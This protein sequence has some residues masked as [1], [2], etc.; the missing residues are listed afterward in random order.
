MVFIKKNTAIASF[1]ILF[2][3][4]VKISFGQTSKIDSLKNQLQKF[5]I[6]DSARVN[7]LN[8]L[9]HLIHRKDIAKA[10]EYIEESTTI[11]KEIRFIKGEA[12]SIY[13]R[14]IIEGATTNYQNGLQYYEQ[15]IQLHK[16][17]NNKK[18]IAECYKGIG[19][20][21]FYKNDRNKAIEYYQKSVEIC[22]EINDKKN[23]ATSL[24]Y[25]AASHLQ[26][27]DYANVIKYAKESLAINEALNDDAGISSSSN[28]IASAYT[29]QSNYPVALEYFNKALTINEKLK[30]TISISNLLI[31]IGVIHYHQEK[32]EK[33]IGYYKKA[34]QFNTSADVLNNLGVVHKDFK[35][36][37]DAIYYLQKALKIYQETNNKSY[38]AMSYNNIADVLIEQHNYDKALTYF[39]KAQLLNTETKNKLGISTSLLGIAK[40]Y[41]NQKKYNLALTHVLKSKQIAEEIKAL[42]YRK[43]I[44]KL[45]A[46]IY[47]ATGKYKKAFLSH[48]EYKT[49][50]DS[51]FN[52]KNIQKTTQ[53]EYEHKYA[54]ELNAASI[55][56]SQLS[57]QVKTTSENLAESQRNLLIGVIS[58]LVIVIIMGSIIFFLK[59][60][61]VAS[62]TE[63]IITEQKLL[64]SQMTPHFIFNSLTV[65]Q[66]MIINKEEQKSVKYLLKFSRLLR[67]I[68]ENSRDKTV[69]LSEEL[70]AIENYLILQNLEN[71]AYQYTILTEEGI[72]VSRFIIPPMIIQP[73]IENAIEHAFTGQT[74]DR[75]IDISFKYSD[76]KLICIITDNGI[77]YQSQKKDKNKQKKSLSSTITEERLKILSREYKMESGICIKNREEYN[78]QGTIVTIILPHKILNA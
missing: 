78:E 39:K 9:A 52:K 5:Q 25:I 74:G 2:F 17:I 61:N 35:Q 71:N 43:D 58:F 53:L 37:T 46:E 50:N 49:L 40:V 57:K 70:K 11:A 18:G 62:K 69:L 26:L 10:K 12:K 16:T 68:L 1:F 38:I 34:L 65:L 30:D 29:Y 8:T 42:D 36:Y 4:T 32:Y 6:R 66:G 73:F 19:T 51:V 15:A 76:S 75:K 56:E 77:G 44:T 7:T 48:K 24:S 64:R 33:A 31:N 14:G 3:M 21:Y 41:T 55:R 20:F 45:L 63:N 27:G 28:I 60:R 47:Y 67:I 72:N 13:I 54:Q 59:L 22:E 23:K